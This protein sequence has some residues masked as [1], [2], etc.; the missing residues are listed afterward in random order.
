M[1]QFL[2]KIEF[3]FYHHRQFGSINGG[4]LGPPNV[5]VHLE[6]ARILISIVFNFYLSGQFRSA[7]GGSLVAP[8]VAV[9]LKLARI[10]I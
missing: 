8:N 9:H 7:S 3:N 10:Y 1:H 6:Q 4:S 2:F 5:A